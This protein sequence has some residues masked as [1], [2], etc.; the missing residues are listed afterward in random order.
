MPQC[1]LLL[2]GTV[3]TFMRCIFPHLAVILLRTEITIYWKSYFFSPLTL[4][5]QCRYLLTLHSSSARDI[6]TSSMSSSASSLLPL[7]SSSLSYIRS[8]FPTSALMVTCPK[9]SSIFDIAVCI[10]TLFT[11]IPLAV[12]R[13]HTL[14]LPSLLSYK[15]SS[16]VQNCSSCCYH[17]SKRS[18]LFPVIE[19]LLRFLCT[20][21]TQSYDMVVH[22][23]SKSMSTFWFV[24]GS[25]IAAC[26]FAMCLVQA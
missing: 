23:P 18:I 3:Y 1:T 9:S 22:R 4:D 11:I 8:H 2:I 15:L 10:I 21:F 16:F 13:I 20:H 26:T 5:A 25:S 7:Y 19:N 12:H 14:P 6:D 24:V 17:V